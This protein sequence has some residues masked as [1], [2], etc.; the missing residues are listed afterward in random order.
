MTASPARPRWVKAR[1]SDNAANCVEV[2]LDALG[3]HVRDS[4]DRGAGPVLTL[5]PGE[6]E[7][8]CAVLLTRVVRDEPVAVA[9]LEVL[10]HADGRL[11]IVGPDA[12]LRYTR[13]ERH[14]FLDGLR[15]AEFSRAAL[16]TR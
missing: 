2:M 8:F 10:V 15:N 9:G 16:T 6:W 13:A 7:R 4:K 14:C 3:Y 11:T 5:S 12:T 1:L